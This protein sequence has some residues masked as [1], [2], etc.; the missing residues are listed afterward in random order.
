MTDDF[1]RSETNPQD[2]TSALVVSDA[3]PEPIFKPEDFSPEAEGD[4]Q[5]AAPAEPPKSKVKYKCRGC[6][7][8][9][10]DSWRRGACPQCCCFYNILKI[11][12]EKMN[13]Y[14]TL[15]DAALRD[16]PPRIPTGI[17]ELDKILGGGF[18]PGSVIVITGDPG[19]GKSSL[20]LQAAAGIA[21]GKRTSKYCSGEE[22]REAILLMAQ[23][24]GISN[25]NVSIKGNA[26]DIYEIISECEQRKPTAL[27]VDSAQ[28]CYMSDIDAD[29]GS[30]RQVDAIAKYLTSYAKQEKVAVFMIS[31]VTKAG[32][33]GGPKSFEHIVDA[34]IRID[35]M[36]IPSQSGENLVPNLRE[37]QSTS[38]NR[39]GASGVKV[40]LEMTGEGLKTPSKKMLRRLSSLEL[41]GGDDDD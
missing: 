15:R 19:A 4:A 22:N 1:D 20:F 38:K 2:L 25:E 10:A 6:G 29:I 13:Q 5:E 39:L 37:L 17:A 11:G 12:K 28:V 33:L 16:P 30:A 23:R 36:N 40:T 21:Q 27:F 41:L 18:L 35:H 26:A 9:A 3:P 24:F 31:H 8:Q 32:E 34:V 7:Y 14:N